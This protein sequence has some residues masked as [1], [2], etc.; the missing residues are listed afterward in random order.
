MVKNTH[1]QT[2]LFFLLLSG[3]FIPRAQEVLAE[4][5]AGET[6]NFDFATLKT[7]FSEPENYFL[8]LKVRT[9]TDIEIQFVQKQ[10]QLHLG[11]FGLAARGKTRVPL[12]N[13]KQLVLHNPTDKKAVIKFRYSSRKEEG[14]ENNTINQKDFMLYNATDMA[15]P[16]LIPGVMNPN[17]SPNSESLVRLRLGQEVYYRSGLKKHLLFKVDDALSQGAIIDVAQLI[18]ALGLEIK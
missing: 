1:A 13:N 11:G 2:L 5:P 12:S 15:I 3:F 14:K 8:E 10:T 9:Q 16:L 7:S 18:Q 17:L 6:I 4:I